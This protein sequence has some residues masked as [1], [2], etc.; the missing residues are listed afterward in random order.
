MAVQITVTDPPNGGTALIASNKVVAT[1][2]VDEAC[3]LIGSIQN[4]AGGVPIQSDE[5]PQ[6][7]TTTVSPW[8]LHFSNP[9][10]NA[11]Y[12]L[13]IRGY[14][15]TTGTGVSITTFQ[16]VSIRQMPPA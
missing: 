4:T 9:V 13:I 5:G 14:S 6:S 12:S 8:T 2:T 3:T 7:L 11:F 10:P 16:A 1:G 15:D